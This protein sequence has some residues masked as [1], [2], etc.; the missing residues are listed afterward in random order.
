[1][2]PRQSL[3]QRFTQW[4]RTQLQRQWAGLSAVLEQS[5][6]CWMERPNLYVEYD[7]GTKNV[8]YPDGRT[9]SVR[10][11]KVRD[12]AGVTFLVFDPATPLS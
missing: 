1:M 6:S 9:R 4:R 11:C 5:H 12:T 7:I 3:H 8:R 2:T 10:T